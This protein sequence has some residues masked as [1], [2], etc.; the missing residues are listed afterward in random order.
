MR[1]AVG[2]VGLEQAGIEPGLIPV[3]GMDTG[4]DINEGIEKSYIIYGIEQELY[5]QGYLSSAIAWARLERL[6][7]PPVVNTGTA[8]VTKTI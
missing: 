5:N 6:N 2:A 3:G 4:P 1:E 7:I 8:G